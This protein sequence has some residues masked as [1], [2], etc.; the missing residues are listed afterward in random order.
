MSENSKKRM[1]LPIGKLDSEIL[2]NAVF[3]NI[4]F[5]SSEVLTGAG[6]GEDCATVDFGEYECVLSTDPITAAV[7]DIGSLAI[8][9]TANDVASN[10]I[11]PLGIML[12]IM[13]PV[14]TTVED[15][16]K[17]MSQAGETA[18]E[19]GIEIIGGHTEIT[20][21]VNTPV[22]VS[23]AV[24]KSEKGKSQTAT[25]MKP[26]DAI[27]MTKYAGLEG[28]G[29]IASDLGEMLMKGVLSADSGEIIQFTE[30]EIREAKELFSHISVVEEGITA[31]E[32]GTAGM[33]DITEGGVLGAVWEMCQ[34][35]ETGCR[36]WLEQIPVKSITKKISK[37]FDIDYLR[38]ISSG[39]MLIVVP[40]HKVTSLLKELN[41]KGIKASWIG[42]IREKNEG[43]LL[44]DRKS[45]E[46]MS[47]AEGREI[48]PPETDELYKAVNR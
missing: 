29:I 37:V 9:I 20:E 7:S 48:L 30:E 14:G 4:K 36:L 27:I 25:K 40:Q 28:T 23:T 38:L 21:A 15:V 6:V 33:H 17:I 8:H 39:C 19:L 26:G 45:T 13:L 44:L 12:A 43:L 18:S 22:I 32:V 34:V 46:P 47:K 2:K 3:N 11:R 10:G 24:G 16:E 5:R 31:A 35:S 41:G 1:P 42:E